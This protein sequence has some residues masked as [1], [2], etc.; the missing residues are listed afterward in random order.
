[1]KR[2]QLKKLN[3]AQTAEGVEKNIAEACFAP[4]EE[5][6]IDGLTLMTIFKGRERHT[7]R[8]KKASGIYIKLQ[9]F[10]SEEGYEDY[11]FLALS[12]DRKL[13]RR[14]AD[15]KKFRPLYCKIYY[16]KL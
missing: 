6:D 13:K 16:K 1:M 2:R 9:S 14:G 4:F 15:G 7:A 8:K 12:A 5:G 10:T 3:G 11:D